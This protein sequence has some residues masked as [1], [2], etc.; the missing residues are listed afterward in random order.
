VVVISV[1]GDDGDDARLCN[2][3][4][5]LCDRRYDQVVYAATHNSMS[6]PDVVFVW[7]EHDGDIRA[8]LDAGVRALLIDTHYWTPLVYPGQLEAADPY[9]P[10]NVAEQA[11]SA[12]R[13]LREGRDGAFLCHNE[14]ALGAVPLDDSL[15]T[16]RG[17]LDDNPDDV[18]TL[19]IQDAITP[20][21]T[22]AAFTRAG[23]D[24]YLH[25]HRSG[26]AWATLGELVDRGERLVVF[27]EDSG[28]PPSWYMPAFELMQETPYRFEQP[29][30]FSCIANRGP[31]D[32]SL[33]L[34]NH[35]VQRIS[36]DR[37]DAVVVNR[38]DAIV[39]RARLCQDE[40]GRLPNYV[41][42]N[43]YGIGDLTAA[44]D[45]LNDVD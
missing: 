3:H 36:P 18:V 21:E 11:F 37:V 25:T 38:H 5:E 4:V 41:A 13:P 29:E 16:I 33:F 14:C 9:L 2:G 19:I 39:D 8:Q 27:A 26:T 34:L 24:P 23:L 30:D 32:A 40:R 20:E 17:F 42:V 28:P 1:A 12:A 31:A 45:T 44:V 35:W 22:A 7:P 6:S 43:F 15:A 10:A